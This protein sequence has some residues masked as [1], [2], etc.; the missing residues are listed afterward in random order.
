MEATTTIVRD[1]REKRDFPGGRGKGRGPKAGEKAPPAGRRAQHPRIP[2]RFNPFQQVTV[3]AAV[4]R[5]TIISRG[6]EATRWVNPVR[7]ELPQAKIIIVSQ[8]DPTVVRR[9]AQEVALPRILPKAIWRTSS[10]PHW[11]EYWGGAAVS[12]GTRVG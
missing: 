3:W 7:R 9:Q 5:L 11:R 4:C 12:S 10:F 1:K 8:N 2:L 6:E